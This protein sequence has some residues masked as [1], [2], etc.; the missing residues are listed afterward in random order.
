MAD[1]SD[2]IKNNAEGAKSAT[3]DGVSVTRHSLREQIE[4]D[5]YIRGLEQQ[6]KRGFPLRRFQV[7]SGPPGGPTRC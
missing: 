1:L 3:A 6:G 7:I 4:A 2:K 5:R